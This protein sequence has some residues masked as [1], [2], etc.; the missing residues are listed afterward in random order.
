L[1]DGV[2]MTKEPGIMFQL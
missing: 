1:I 2:V